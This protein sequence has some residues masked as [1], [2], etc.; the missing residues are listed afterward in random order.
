MICKWFMLTL[1]F[2]EILA[3]CSTWYYVVIPEQPTPAKLWYQQFDHVFKGLRQERVSLDRPWSACSL[4]GREKTSSYDIET[5]HTRFIHPS[6]HLI[7]N[8][9]RCAYARHAQ[10]ANYDMFSQSPFGPLSAVH[11]WR[12]L[13]ES[14]N[15][16]SNSVALD[17]SQLFIVTWSRQ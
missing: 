11:I 16:T 6:F 8:L 7:S 4:R 14:F 5:I 2:K 3:I 13:Q 12:T 15:V 1:L 17:I 10:S 9:C